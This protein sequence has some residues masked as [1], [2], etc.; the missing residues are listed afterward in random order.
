M[1]V[2]Y[3]LCHYFAVIPP[4]VSGPSLKNSLKK[5]SKIFHHFNALNLIKIR[6]NNYFDD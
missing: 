6:K 4:Q 3:Y 5:K 1:T 2:K